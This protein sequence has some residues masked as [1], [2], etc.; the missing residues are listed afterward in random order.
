MSTVP[1][2]KIKVRSLA[3]PVSVPRDRGE[4]IRN[5]WASNNDSERL[6]NLGEGLVCRFKDIVWIKDD[7]DI[8]QESFDE[9][10]QRLGDGL[11]KLE[12]KEIQDNGF[13]TRWKDPNTG[14]PLQW[15]YTDKD[16]M[17]VAIGR[18]FKKNVF[19]LEGVKQ[20]NE[21]RVLESSGSGSTF[22]ATI[23]LCLVDPENKNG[24]LEMLDKYTADLL[25]NGR[26][27]NP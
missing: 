25:S 12:E 22:Q 7:Y 14:K 20:A 10:V 16:G 4:S 1:I 2:C 18:W 15:M 27:Y 6:V 9:Y 26:S 13:S 11:D 17:R 19:G 21:A 23:A 5:Y 24:D 8:R 3:D